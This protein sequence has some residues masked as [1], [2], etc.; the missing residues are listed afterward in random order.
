MLSSDMG[1]VPGSERS[2][3]L[4]DFRCV[5]ICGSTAVRGRLA[6]C[7]KVRMRDQ[8]GFSSEWVCAL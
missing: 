2:V 4:T 5:F 7:V 6:T 1:W 8:A 3:S